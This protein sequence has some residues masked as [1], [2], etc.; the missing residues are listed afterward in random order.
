MLVKLTF[1]SSFCAVRVPLIKRFCDFVVTVGLLVLALLFRSLISPAQLFLL[2]F[3]GLSSLRLQALEL[4]SYFWNYDLHNDYGELQR[5]HIHW[6]Q[7]D[8]TLLLHFFQKATT[9][10]T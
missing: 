1:H 4:R 5:R 9:L 2:L 10:A 7:F 8:D 3:A 6:L